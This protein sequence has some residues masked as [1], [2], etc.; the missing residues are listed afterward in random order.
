M[1]MTDQSGVVRRPIAITNWKSVVE[2]TLTL[3]SK[4]GRRSME[5]SGGIQFIPGESMSGPEPDGIGIVA[6]LIE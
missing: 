2:D 3:R 4:C 1:S 6:L 5:P